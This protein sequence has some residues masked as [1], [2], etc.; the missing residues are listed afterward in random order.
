MRLGR[1]FDVPLEQRHVQCPCNFFG[2]QR[3]A[4]ARLTLDEQR[5][6]Q[7]NG[8]IDRQGQ[9]ARGDIAIGT[10]EFH[11]LSSVLGMRGLYD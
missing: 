8:G 2:E 6:L 4:G 9:V 10:F 1:R 7:G 3:L 5:T 11:C